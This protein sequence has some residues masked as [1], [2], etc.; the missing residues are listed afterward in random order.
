MTKRREF[1]E[2]LG[3]MLA[4]AGSAQAE[5]LPALPDEKPQHRI[6]FAVCGVSTDHIHGM[7]GALTRGGGELV[8]WWGEE[9]D[10]RTVFSR[11]YPNAKAA[12]EQAEVLQDSSVQLVLSS[13]IASQ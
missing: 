3:G 6:K 7:I 4:L 8:A 11:R 2:S 13:Q 10:K 1:L 5:T 9:P 12:R